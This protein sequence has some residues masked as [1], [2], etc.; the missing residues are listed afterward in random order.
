MR[1]PMLR[2]SLVD[3]RHAIARHYDLS[4]HAANATHGSEPRL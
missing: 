2:E 4:Y 1:L 3:G